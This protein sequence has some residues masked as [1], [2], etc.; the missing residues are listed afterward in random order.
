MIKAEEAIKFVS[1]ERQSR[2]LRRWRYIAVGLLVLLLLVIVTKDD[3][4][5]EAVSGGPFIGL[6]NIEGILVED[7]QRQSWLNH[8]N[9]DENGKA[10]IVR[11]NSPGGT[12][13]GGEDLYRQLQGIA[14]RKPVAVVMG[15][16]ATSAAYMA[17]LGA[18]RVFSHEGTITGS[19]GVVMQVLQIHDLLEKLGI[20][21]EVFKSGELKAAPNPL[22]P[23]T[24]WVRD[25]TEQT[26][27]EM[28][29]IFVQMVV[30]NRGLTRDEVLNLADGR[31]FSGRQAVAAGL[32]DE[33]GGQAKAM[34]WLFSVKNIDKELPIENIIPPKPLE[35]FYRQLLGAFTAELGLAVSPTLIPNIGRFGGLVSVWS[36]G[37]Y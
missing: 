20:K 22:E 33:L 16:V 5:A 9:D 25:M 18:E 24:P 15:E 32:V 10:L 36:P 2:G 8:F 28:Q 34:R 17:S 4:R 14:V 13:V 27:A 21:A 26:I 1:Y 23:I 7:Y 12:V 6:L 35:G 29:D 31:I 37:A 11:I 3:Q 19:I 30:D